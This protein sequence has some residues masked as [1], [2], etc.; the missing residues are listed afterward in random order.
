MQNITA[1][2]NLGM[3]TPKLFVTTTL[4]D[5]VVKY[6]QTHLQQHQTHFI[7]DNRSVFGRY[8]L[9]MV[10][11]HHYQHT[12]NGNIAFAFGTRS[13][14]HLIHTRSKAYQFSFYIPKKYQRDIND[15]FTKLIIHEFCIKYEAIQQTKTILQAVIDFKEY[16][17]FTD[18]DMSD[19][20]LMRAWG[21]FK[22]SK[23]LDFITS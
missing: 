21:R 14:E 15:F 6:L 16:Y 3:Q 17:H 8:I 13:I 2:L 12:E 18:D 19:F 9:S 22:Q 11:R 7:L 1:I 10:R 20:A 5:K 4:S 23:K